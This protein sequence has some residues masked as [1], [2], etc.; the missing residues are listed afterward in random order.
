MK[1]KE[2]AFPAAALR[3][4]KYFLGSLISSVVAAA[5]MLFAVVEW[6]YLNKIAIVPVAEAVRVNERELTVWLDEIRGSQP[7]PIS[8]ITSEKVTDLSLWEGYEIEIV[9]LCEEES[10][11]TNERIYEIF[12]RENA[13]LV[14]PLIPQ[15]QGAQNTNPVVIPPNES[16]VTIADANFSPETCARVNRDQARFATISAVF[17][18]Q[19]P[20]AK[21]RFSKRYYV[22]TRPKPLPT[23]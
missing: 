6:N 15:T 3:F 22:V 4:D 1:A 16:D 18:D 13:K 17:D 11:R 14:I 12:K 8:E 7:R 20:S 21:R 9:A 5:G 10:L 2:T 23:K 19:L